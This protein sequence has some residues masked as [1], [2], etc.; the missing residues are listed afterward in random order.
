VRLIGSWAW[1]P[2]EFVDA[3]ELIGSGAIDRKPLISHE[4]ALEDAAEAYAT[5]DSAAT[6]IK[7]MLVP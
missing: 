2:Q 6:A 7:V 1:L 3:L 5:Q 4:F